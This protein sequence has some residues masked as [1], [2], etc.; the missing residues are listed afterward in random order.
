[1]P[2]LDG[3]S[4]A[5]RPGTMSVMNSQ[6]VDVLRAGL[7]CERPRCP[8]QRAR[9]PVHCPA[10]RDVRPSLGVAERGGRMLVRCHA[11]CSQAA[12][13]DA[14]RAR[15]LWPSRRPHDAQAQRQRSAVSPLEA[16]RREV[17]GRARREPWAR[18]GVLD[19][20]VASD[21]IRAARRL[22]EL[23]RAEAREDDEGVWDRLELAAQ[24]EGEMRLLEQTLDAALA[25]SGA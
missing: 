7:R 24:V 18:P 22:V 1:M 13:L 15:G 19:V 25:G 9:G 8:C 10:H 23:V 11:G 6:L 12:V 4:A 3:P 21:A 5:D 17:L 14:L 20:Y 2:I 16:A